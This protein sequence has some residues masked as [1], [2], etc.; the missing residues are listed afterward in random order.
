[1]AFISNWFEKIFGKN[2]EIE[3]IEALA[4]EQT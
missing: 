1:M 3:V 2:N 4:K